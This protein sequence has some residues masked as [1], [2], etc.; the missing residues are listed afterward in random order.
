MV[1]YLGWVRLMEMV[2]IGVWRERV[3]WTWIPVLSKY[4]C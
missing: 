1:I 3:V 4:L 2:I